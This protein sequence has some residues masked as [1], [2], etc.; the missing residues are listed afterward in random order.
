[1]TLARLRRCRRARSLTAEDAAVAPLLLELFDAFAAHQRPPAA[2]VRRLRREL[3]ARVLAAAPPRAWWRY[4]AAL[5]RLARAEPAAVPAA[6]ARTLARPPRRVAT[7][8]GRR[9]ADVRSTSRG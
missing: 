8:L 6:M 2:E 9:L 1:V 5:T 7:A 3:V 4:T